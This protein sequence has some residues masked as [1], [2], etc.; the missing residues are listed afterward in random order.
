M[1]QAVIQWGCRMPER[2]LDLF[3]ADDFPLPTRSKLYCLPLLDD[4]GGAQE[5]LLNYV[6]RLAREHQLRVM[7]LLVKVVLPETS[8]TVHH[9]RFRFARTDSRTV[10]GYG[11]YSEELTAALK[12]LTL[13][14]QLDRATF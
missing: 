10:N 7:D 6:H 12:R 8:V 4:G 13:N 5:S 9:G 14:K 2:C 3:E 11:K 1:A